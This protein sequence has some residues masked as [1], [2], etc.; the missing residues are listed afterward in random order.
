MGIDWGKCK[1][2]QMGKWEVIRH[3]QGLGKAL[4]PSYI[5]ERGSREKEI[6]A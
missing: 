1:V 5:D 2:I 6:V 3:R 4:T